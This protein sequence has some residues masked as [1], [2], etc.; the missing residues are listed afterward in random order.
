MTSRTPITTTTSPSEVTMLREKTSPRAVIG[1]ALAAVAALAG[2]AVGSLTAQVEVPMS[3][4]LEPGFLL[5]MGE[6]VDPAS[7]SDAETVVGS[8]GETIVLEHS[9][10]PFDLLYVPRTVEGRSLTAGDRVQFFRLDRRIGDPATG[11]PLGRLLLPTGVARVEA[12]EGEIATVRVTDA[13]HPI[14]VGDRV[15]LVN[16]T[17]EAW[18]TATVAPGSAGGRIVAFQD[19]KAIHPTFDKLSLRPEAAGAA[20]PGQVVELYRPGCVRDGVQLPDR[21]LG[22]AMVVRVEGALAAAVTFERKGSDLAPGDL[23]RAVQPEGVE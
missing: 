6:I 13:F 21:V 12:I 8:A 11:E 18:P 3:A 1:A 16:E 17:D 20:G 10:T 15:R 14:L 7:W 19:E 23:Y 5:S 9:H 4:L 22:K 2:P